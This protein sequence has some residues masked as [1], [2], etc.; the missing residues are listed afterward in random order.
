MVDTV[1]GIL[2]GR[3]AEADLSSRETARA[4]STQS[5]AAYELGNSLPS[6]HIGE[7]AGLIEL[8]SAHGGHEGLAEIADEL[9][10]ELDDLLPVVDAVDLAKLARSENGTLRAD[11]VLTDLRHTYGEQEARTQ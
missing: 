3:W 1:Y 2:T 5:E 4:K 9:R 6:A 7:I 10:Y 11:G 8:L